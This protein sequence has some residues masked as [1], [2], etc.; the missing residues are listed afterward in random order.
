MATVCAQPGAGTGPPVVSPQCT[1][2]SRAQQQPLQAGGPALQCLFQ[3][4][5]LL[6]VAQQMGVAEGVHDLLSISDGQM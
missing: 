6:Q 1:T 3:F 2:V 4:Y 5:D